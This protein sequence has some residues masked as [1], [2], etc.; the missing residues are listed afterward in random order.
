MHE[1]AIKRILI[2]GATGAIGQALV[3]AYALA[4]RHLC[5]QGRN[6]VILTQQADWLQQ[7]GCSVELA[8]LDL[9][10]QP[11]R[12]QW[13]DHL[14]TQDFDLVILNHGININH[15]PDDAGETWPDVQKL[16]QLNVEASFALVHAVLPAMRRRGQGQIAL[17]S[18]LAAWYGLP[19]TPSYS[20][21][22]AALKAY[23]EGLRGWLKP[24]GVQVNV[25][26]PGY[27]DSD[28]SRAMPGPKPWLWPPERAAAYIK[29]GLAANHAR[30]SFP[31]PLNLG[32]FLLGFSRPWLAE[33]ILAWLNYRG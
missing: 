24:Q 3:Q 1:D 27:V 17:M 14:L 11:A 32:C 19:V 31:F 33:R 15:G 23:G 13:C 16:L 7:Q 8:V 26:M 30:I 29:R 10:E 4:G 9:T 25:V 18:S 22:K 6:Q 20:A 12:Q 21:S 5:L 2:T 28:M